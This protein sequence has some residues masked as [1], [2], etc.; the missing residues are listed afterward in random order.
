MWFGACRR[1]L[2]SHRA[3]QTWHGCFVLSQQGCYLG[4]VGCRDETCPEIWPAERREG[5]LNVKFGYCPG[6][7]LHKFLGEWVLWYWSYQSFFP[8]VY[9]FLAFMSAHLITPL[10]VMNACHWIRG[11]WSRRSLVWAVTHIVEQWQGVTG[12]KV[13]HETRKMA[14]KM[15]TLHN[16]NTLRVLV[17][18]CASCSGSTIS[19]KHPP[20]PVH[21]QATFSKMLILHSE[22]IWFSI[23]ALVGSMTSKL[24]WA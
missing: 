6:C 16:R 5:S 18:A 3:F 7:H 4:E 22:V 20:C 10:P 15:L 23:L 12:G 24:Q 11:R 19:L 2:V 14:L 17:S 13:E 8:S 21:K 9:L 1:E